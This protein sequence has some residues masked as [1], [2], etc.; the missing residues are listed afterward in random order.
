MSVT[1]QSHFSGGVSVGSVDSRDV[2]EASGLAAS[3][4]HAN[5]LYTHNDGGDSPRI[6]AIDA[7]DASLIATLGISGADH[8][9][10][11]ILPSGPALE[12][13]RASTYQMQVTVLIGRS[14]WCIWF[15]SLVL[16]VTNP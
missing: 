6:F 10:R 9:D 3:R 14:T 15:Q 16:F 12:I 8:Y 1:A 7:T 13:N 11:R 2:N 4:I 5:V